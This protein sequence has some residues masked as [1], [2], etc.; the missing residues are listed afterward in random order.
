MNKIRIGPNLKPLEEPLESIADWEKFKYG[1]L[2]TLRQDSDVKPFIIEDFEF[3]AK[4]EESPNRDLEDD[5]DGKS[6]E[7]KCAIIDFMLETIHQFTPKIPH[8]DIVLECKSL[9]EVWQVIRLHSN[10]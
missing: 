9:L 6:A 2:Y 5:T 4:T 8:D 10:I 3:G 7:E 1:L